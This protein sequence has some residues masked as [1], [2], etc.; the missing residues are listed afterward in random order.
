MGQQH[1]QQHQQQQHQQQQH[2][3]Q[4][5][6]ATQPQLQF[7]HLA[8]MVR[9]PSPAPSHKIAGAPSSEYQRSQ[10]HQQAHQQLLNTTQMQGNHLSLGTP[11]IQAQVLTQVPQE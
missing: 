8:A 2:Q 6:Q 4:H 11:R 10:S 1:Q 9:V 3:Q 5:Q 7:Q